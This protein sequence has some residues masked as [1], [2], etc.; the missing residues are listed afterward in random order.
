M[1]IKETVS[2]KHRKEKFKV[3]ETNILQRDAEHRR[4]DFIVA[5]EIH[6]AVMRPHKDLDSFTHSTV[7]TEYLLCARHQ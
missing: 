2:L 7:F 3:L 5:G 1:N 6:S 4:Y